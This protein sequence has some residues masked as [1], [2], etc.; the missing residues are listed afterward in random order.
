MNMDM[1]VFFFFFFNDWTQTERVIMIVWMD[2]L[3]IAS[4]TVRIFTLMGL[5][6]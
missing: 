3:S 4:V 6:A 2:A 1:L 5:E